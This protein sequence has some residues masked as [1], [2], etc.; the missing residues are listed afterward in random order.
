MRKHSKDHS[1]SKEIDREAYLEFENYRFFLLILFGDE[2]SDR[3]EVQTEL[4]AQY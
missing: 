2:Y 3:Y 4:D 1:V